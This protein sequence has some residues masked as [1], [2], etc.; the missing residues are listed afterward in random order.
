[1]TWAICRQAARLATDACA[2]DVRELK[3][4]V[5][6]NHPRAVDCCATGGH[7]NQTDETPVAESPP[8]VNDSRDT[9]MFCIL[10]MPSFK[11]RRSDGV[12]GLSCVI[13]ILFFC[14]LAGP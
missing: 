3:L 13:G 14:V 7:R 11:R 5:F 10:M 8:V 2:A 4:P 1:M 12:F 9:Q 6:G